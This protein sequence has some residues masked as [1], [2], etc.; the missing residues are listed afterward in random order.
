MP[1]LFE[2]PFD[3][4]RK[5][6]TVARRRPDGTVRA[7]VKGAPDVILLRASRVLEGGRIVALDDETRRAISSETQ[8]MG[9]RA[10][11]VLA[12]A[13][14][15]LDPSADDRSADAVERDL[16][17]AGLAGMQDP[18]RPE[19]KRAV[20][21]CKEA[22]I[23]VVMVTGDHPETALAIGREL[24]IAR[25]DGRAASGRELDA[26]DDET[27]RAQAREIDV[28]AR[29]TAAHKLRIVR[30]L[31]AEGAVVAMTGDGVND[32][33]A[34]KGA[35][36]GIA[37]GRSGTEVTKEA[38]DMVITDDNFATI[39]A[40]VEEG[41]GIYANIRKTI[42]YLLAGNVGELLFVTACVFVGLPMPLA[43]IQLLWINLVTDGIP[44]LCLATDP[45]DP[46][47]MRAAPREKGRPLAD[48][49]FLSRVLLTGVLVS[50]ITMTVYCW[51][52]RSG[53]VERARAHAFATFVFI[54]LLGSFAFLSETKPAWRTSRASILRLAIVVVAGIGIQLAVPHVRPLGDRLQVMPTSLAGCLSLLAIAVVPA[55]LLELTK[56]L[57][58]TRGT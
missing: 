32:A 48:R 4:D 46:D 1:A 36:I 7:L 41:R 2:I 12:A 53:G 27:L 57:R 17:F 9:A 52:L 43:A 13:F 45:L 37:M 33:P 10:L 26:L 50:G 51:T 28:Y 39:V 29:V 11:R 54:E 24:G 15:D 22:G 56:V 20:A 8:A 18:P 25:S 23:R 47:V 34:I 3:S 58:R 55:L 40:A 6:M 49:P 42:S 16:V 21:S 14:R 31:K 5:R 38:S 44:A 35:D 30:A 19:A